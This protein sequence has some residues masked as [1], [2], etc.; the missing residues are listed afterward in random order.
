MRKDTDIRSDLTLCDSQNRAHALD[1]N[2]PI[3]SDL[4]QMG[5]GQLFFKG[6]KA[7][8]PG[9]L[10]ES[11]VAADFKA[12]EWILRQGYPASSGRPPPSRH[13][14]CICLA[15][16]ILRHIENRKISV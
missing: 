16:Q 8:H 9:L 3:P 1:S 14:Q 12:D 15:G 5:A 2:N 6:L 11:A 7:D 13:V 4:I 10:A